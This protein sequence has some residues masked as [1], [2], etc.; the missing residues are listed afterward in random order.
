MRAEIPVVNF[1]HHSEDFK[2][3][4][5]EIYEEFRGLCPVVHS[6]THDGFDVISRY[7]DVG[8]IARD[9]ERFSSAAESLLIPSNRARKL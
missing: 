7:A 9:P 6:P 5:L 3:R 4:R 2:E 1:D 8:E